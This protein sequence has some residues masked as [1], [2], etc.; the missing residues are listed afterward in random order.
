M[1]GGEVRKESMG[2][3]KDGAPL[4]Q[5]D[6]C[7]T[8]HATHMRNKGESNLSSVLK[9]PRVHY[10]R[11]DLLQSP[12]DL[13]SI[14]SAHSMLSLHSALVCSGEQQAQGGDGERHRVGVFYKGK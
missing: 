3:V 4:V 10:L 9:K 8:P 13:A 11:E 7:P 1:H 2:G 5:T 6:I 12:P 14:Y